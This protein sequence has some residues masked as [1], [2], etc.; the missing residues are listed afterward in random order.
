MKQATKRFLSLI[1]VFVFVVAAF[2]VYF[3]L[4]QPAYGGAQAV[5]AEQI[6]KQDFVNTQK[7]VVTEVQGL[8]SQSQ[9]Q[10]QLEQAIA[11]VLPQTPDPASVIAQMNGLAQ[12]NHLTL[13]SFSVSTPTLQGAATG[14]GSSLVKPVGTMSFEVRLTGSYE[15]FKNFLANAETNIRVF[16]LK[17]LSLQPGGK[18]TD[19]IYAYDM[20]FSAYYQ[21]Q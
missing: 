17:T 18:P 4:I 5:Q 11:Y 12:A 15:D 3:N 8:I 21:S 13:Q 6:S 10:S 19:D 20:I 16:D 9:S 1:L 2:F 14:S 7:T